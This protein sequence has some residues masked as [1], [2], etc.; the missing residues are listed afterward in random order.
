[1]SDTLDRLGA[2]L[3][4]GANKVTNPGSLIRLCDLSSTPLNKAISYK[5]DCQH[6]P[7]S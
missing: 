6:N 2:L 4:K 3:Q 1:M 5:R 7:Q